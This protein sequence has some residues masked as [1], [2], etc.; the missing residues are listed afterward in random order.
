MFSFAFRVCKEGGGKKTAESQ[1]SG[2]A[3]YLKVEEAIFHF[4]TR[5]LRR[6]EPA[7][8]RVLSRHLTSSVLWYGGASCTIVV[9]WPALIAAL[10]SL[11]AA[12]QTQIIN[13]V[14]R[15][16]RNKQFT[17]NPEIKPLC[18][19]LE[20]I[21]EGRRLT[22]SKFSV[23]VASE[24]GVVLPHLLKGIL[25]QLLRTTAVCVG[26]YAACRVVDSSTRCRGVFFSRG[27]SLSSFAFYDFCLS[28][29]S[30]LER[31][32]PRLLV[33][34]LFLS[35]LPAIGFLPLS[36]A[37]F[38]WMTRDEERVLLH[39]FAAG[40][41]AAWRLCA[42]GPQLIDLLLT[43]SSELLRSRQR[44]PSDPPTSVRL[45]RIARS[46]ALVCVGAAAV[47][48]AAHYGP[49]LAPNALATLPLVDGRG[50]AFAASCLMDGLVSTKIRF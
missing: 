41:Y 19:A 40:H 31:F 33:L 4:L 1:M 12:R 2:S 42:W 43:E 3:A 21:A 37:G 7:A 13:G 9:L 28:V 44:K 18:P 16:L 39:S 30:T 46:A 5:V 22:K 36:G 48:A 24:A 20:R 50:A 47:A 27:W 23:L 10:K 26:M 8:L 35:K 32:F 29:P 14:I 15:I 11:A 25:H 34:P 38:R 17:S 45:W 49:K 6:D